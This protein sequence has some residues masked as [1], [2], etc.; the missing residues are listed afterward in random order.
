MDLE[1][2]K[3]LTD[4][5]NFAFFFSKHLL[6]F[7]L[8]KVLAAH[9]TIVIAHSFSME[10]IM[11]CASKLCPAKTNGTVKA[12]IK[13]LTEDTYKYMSIIIILG[14]FHH[15]ETFSDKLKRPRTHFYPGF[16]PA[17]EITPT[18]W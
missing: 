16:K 13:H 3:A 8:A 17:K 5:K 9:L 18:R 11:N 4:R 12:S 7:T 10:G 6:K 14:N 15:L 1:I 2:P